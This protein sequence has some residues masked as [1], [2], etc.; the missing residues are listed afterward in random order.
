M[1]GQRIRELERLDDL[2][3]ACRACLFWESAGVGPGPSPQGAAGKE[4]WWRATELEWGVPGKG[5]YADD[6]LV[7]YVTYGPPDHFPRVRAAGKTASE[8]ALLLATLWVAPEHRGG[9]VAK[10]LLQ[11]ALREAARRGL[12]AVEALAA[13][14]PSPAEWHCVLPADFL[15]AH[16][17]AVFQDD[18]VRP[19]LRLD[20]RQTVRWQEQM[21]Q[22]LESVVRVLSRRERAPQPAPEAGLARTQG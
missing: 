6:A 3:E 11:V 9:G 12:R 4:A 10:T 22:A 18:P 15:L 13:R 5:V 7:G 14:D 21:G 2:P 17:F 8:D 16:G 1:V 20:L 19:L